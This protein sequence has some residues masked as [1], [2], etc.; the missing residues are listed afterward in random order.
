MPRLRV[1][2]SPSNLPGACTNRELSTEE[3]PV[4]RIDTV[5]CSAGDSLKLTIESVS[6]S[7][8][9]GVWLG[10]QGELLVA[11]HRETQFVVWADTAPRTVRV[12]IVATD[13]GLLRLYNVWD[14]G[15]GLGTESLTHTSGMVKEE[16]PGGHRYSCNAIGFDPQFDSIRF[17]LTRDS[18]A[19]ARGVSSD[20]FEDE[21]ASS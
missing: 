4:W 21:R 13:D 1:R 18:G 3:R 19:W 14:S 10:V 8:R 11:V 16:V 7:W 17:T 2:Y 9:H 15:R 6:P 12:E 5:E 20:H